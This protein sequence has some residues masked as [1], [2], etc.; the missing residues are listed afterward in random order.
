MGGGEGLGKRAAAGCEATM[1]AESSSSLPSTA[2]LFLFECIVKA[3]SRGKHINKT[4][5]QI[6]GLLLAYFIGEMIPH[7]RHHFRK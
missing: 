1:V 2:L 7:P 6:V 4:N 3:F 5:T